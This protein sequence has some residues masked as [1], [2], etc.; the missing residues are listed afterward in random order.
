MDLAGVLASWAAVVV[1]VIVAIRA[2]V[3]ERRAKKSAEDAEDLRRRTVKASERSAI[4]VE[5]VAAA[6]RDSSNNDEL[7]DDHYRGP[8]W[9]LDYVSGS[10]YALVNKTQY[11]QTDVTIS[12][13]AVLRGPV[14][15]L[16]V[17]AFQEVQFM[18]LNSWNVSD[19]VTVTWIDN[20]NEKQEWT[21]AL[22]PKR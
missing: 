5:E 18:G 10:K 6:I 21:V 3:S 2:Y 8:T 7:A 13:D 9:S 19:Q 11:A 17:P 16:E 14:R 4:A 1:A 12:G 22:P 15:E 20:L